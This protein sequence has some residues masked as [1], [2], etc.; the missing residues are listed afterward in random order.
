MSLVIIFD[1]LL[2]FLLLSHLIKCRWTSTRTHNDKQINVLMLR[3]AV[4]NDLVMD[5]RLCVILINLKLMQ[6]FPSYMNFILHS[7][8]YQL[9]SKFHLLTTFEQMNCPNAEKSWK[10][11]W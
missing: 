9:T 11:V 1:S 8:E 7:I 10:L 3:V 5:I 6:C 4:F 2:Q